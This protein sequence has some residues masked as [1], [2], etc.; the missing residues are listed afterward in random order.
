MRNMT[1]D[2][3]AKARLTGC[4]PL[5]LMKNAICSSTRDFGLNGYQMSTLN[6]QPK[7]YLALVGF[8]KGQGEDLQV[9]TLTNEENKLIVI[10][11]PTVA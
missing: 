1:S 5:F 10:D 8:F 4:M 2:L 6:L 9:I 3:V 7:S 11:N